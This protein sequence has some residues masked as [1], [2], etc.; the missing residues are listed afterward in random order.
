M[1]EVVKVPFL[2]VN[3]L[4]CRFASLENVEGSYVKMGNLICTLETTKTS[5]DITAP[6]DGYL[7]LYPKTGDTLKIGDTIAIISDIQG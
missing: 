6:V 3:D 7:Y 2:G 4:D 5:Y 1:N